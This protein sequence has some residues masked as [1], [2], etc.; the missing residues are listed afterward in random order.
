M[1]FDVSCILFDLEEKVL[2]KQ[3]RKPR[4]EATSSPRTLKGDDLLGLLPSQP[5]LESDCIKSNGGVQGVKQKERPRLAFLNPL[6]CALEG[7]LKLSHTPRGAVEI[8]PDSG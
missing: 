8:S 6:L 2:H 4:M 5:H 7:S 3:K 1:Y